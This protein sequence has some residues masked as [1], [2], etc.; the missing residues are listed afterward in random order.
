[1]NDGATLLSRS[2]AL[3]SAPCPGGTRNLTHSY[4]HDEH[5]MLEQA[6]SGTYEKQPNMATL[7]G[8]LQKTIAGDQLML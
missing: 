2:G 6:C 1:M 5:L 4:G 3:R 7:G 8:M